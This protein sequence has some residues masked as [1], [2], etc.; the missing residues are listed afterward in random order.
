MGLPGTL[1]IV[2]VV[3]ELKIPK[4][5]I[6]YIYFYNYLLR[7]HI[8]SDSAMQAVRFAHQLIAATLDYK[9]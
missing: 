8:N 7:I 6:E 2:C 3:L 1:G 4:M 5:L 9:F